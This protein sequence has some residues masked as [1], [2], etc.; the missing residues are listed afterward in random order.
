MCRIPRGKGLSASLQMADRCHEKGV[1]PL[2]WVDATIGEIMAVSLRC[3]QGSGEFVWRWLFQKEDFL[4]VL[5][6]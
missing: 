2:Q 4:Q 1:W 6:L 3:Q 5:F